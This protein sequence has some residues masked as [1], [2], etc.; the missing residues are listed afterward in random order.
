MCKCTINECLNCKKPDCDN[1]YVKKEYKYRNYLNTWAKDR[2][3]NREA[4]GLCTY[5]GKR[6]PVNG[7]KMCEICQAKF[8][9][10]KNQEEYKRGRKPR[11]LLDGISLC[12]KCGKYAPKEGF[13]VCERCYESN[14]RNLSKTPTHRGIKREGDKFREGIDAFWKT[15]RNQ[16]PV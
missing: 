5:C 9:E 1:D 8:R 2:R 6:L 14:L 11:G 3:R 4:S 13:R 15:S 12:A 10:Y 16:N 7:H